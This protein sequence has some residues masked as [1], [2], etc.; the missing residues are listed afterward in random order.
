MYQRYTSTKICLVSFENNI[1]KRLNWGL[2]GNSHK[3]CK[4][5]ALKDFLIIEL[6]SFNACRHA[7]EG[8]NVV[9]EAHCKEEEN[10]C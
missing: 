10:A 5:H 9:K 1:S 6:A 7:R 8:T 3:E 2:V 4:E